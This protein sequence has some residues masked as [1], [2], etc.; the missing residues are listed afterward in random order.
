M[1]KRLMMLGVAA[2]AAAMAAS[3]QAATVFDFTTGI[4]SDSGSTLRHALI[5]LPGTGFTE[6]ATMIVLG[7]VLLTAFRGSRQV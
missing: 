4:A 2:I 1:S 6:P 3:A 5:L 7:T